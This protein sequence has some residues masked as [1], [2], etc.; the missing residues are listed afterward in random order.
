MET[1]QAH[2]PVVGAPASSRASHFRWVI[3]SLLFFACLINYMDR[4]VLGLL[5]PDLSRLF[6]WTEKDYGRMA[7][8]FQAAYAIGQVLFGPL[9]AWVGTKRAYAGSVLFWSLAAMSHSL[10]RSVFGFCS[11][12]FALGLGESGNYPTAIRTVTEWFPARERSLATGIFNTGSNLGAVFAPALVP[13]IVAALSWKAAFLVL[14]LTDLVWLGFWLRLYQPPE[15]SSRVSPEELRHIQSDSGQGAQEKVPWVK[16]LRFRE[17]W[18]YYGTCVLVGPVWWFY[19]F[20]LPDFFNK[21]FHLNLKQFG[22]PLVVVYSV[23]ALGSIGGG[24]LSAWLIK[25]GW[26][27]NRARK[28]ASLLCAI[29]TLPVIFAPRVDSVWLATGFFA[30]AAAAHQGW[31]ATMYTAVSDLFPKGAVASVVGLGGTLAS[32]MSLGFFWLVSTLLQSEGTYRTILLLCGS[33]YVVAWIIF[34]V[35]VPQIKPVRLG[36]SSP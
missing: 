27:L 19:G 35:G 22:L 17:A 13:L 28:A 1:Q 18:A 30:L 31:S 36:D 23:T 7:I 33:A 34:Q 15:K 24:G 4:Q 12:R 21:Q 9:I 6:G 3:C 29:C 5:K 25:R 20:W 8:A 11:A 14:G 2:S 32:L 16:L 26:P 10:A